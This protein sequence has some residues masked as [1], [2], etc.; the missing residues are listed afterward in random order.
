M[1]AKQAYK[2]ISQ[3]IQNDKKIDKCY[4]YN[5]VFVFS[6][7]PDNYTGKAPLLGNL[8]SIDKETGEIKSF[9]PMILTPGEY[10]TGKEITDF[11]E[12]GELMHDSREIGKEFI[13][14]LLEETVNEEDSLQHYGVLGMKW[15]VRRTEAQL[16]RATERVNK[17]KAKKKEQD[18][19]I[20]AKNK[21]A[22][23]K[24]EEKSLKSK[25]KG[26]HEKVD[27]IKDK[28]KDTKD[29]HPKKKK[30]SEMTNEELQARIDRINLEKRYSELV[31]PSNTETKKKIFDGRS[32]I[33]TVSQRSAEELGT[34][35]TK[36]FGAK[37]LN[38][39]MGE[40]AVYANN[41]KK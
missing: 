4:E 8:F 23:M 36:H 13:R 21:L 41:K 30:I 5:T 33:S 39:L 1:D 17:L 38:K 3:K 32:F 25:L 14:S 12:G 22:K 2:I 16:G 15:G 27:K 7:V 31:N 40:E 24:A 6:V 18:K 19:L 9:T 37:L 26:K 29:K 10:Q 20:R 35:V 11:K 28:I 34:Q